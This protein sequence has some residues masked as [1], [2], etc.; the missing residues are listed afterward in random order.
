MSGDFLPLVSPSPKN[1]T[2]ILVSCQPGFQGHLDMGTGM[3]DIV[4]LEGFATGTHRPLEAGRSYYSYYTCDKYSWIIHLPTHQTHVFTYGT[5]RKRNKLVEKDLILDCIFTL[6]SYYKWLEEIL[7][8][9][10]FGGGVMDRKKQALLER[11][12]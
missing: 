6:E 8:K 5:V 1:H 9:K 11:R 12:N 2:S 3:E 7:Y 4:V 10:K